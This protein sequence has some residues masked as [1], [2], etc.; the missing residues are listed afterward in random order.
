MRFFYLWYRFF[1]FN[2]TFHS[3]C[4]E[5]LLL[6][7]YIFIVQ[8]ADIDQFY[9]YKKAMRF[10]SFV[11]FLYFSI[12]DKHWTLYCTLFH[13]LSFSLSFCHIFTRTHNLVQLNSTRD[14][15]CICLSVCACA[16][17]LIFFSVFSV[18]CAVFESQRIG[19]DSR[20]LNSK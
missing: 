18:F 12:I 13:S 5:S 7:T 17:C 19:L 14:K 2:S 15:H 16:V 10:F 9:S 3:G 8:L 20:I 4:S 6:I 1:L 11:L